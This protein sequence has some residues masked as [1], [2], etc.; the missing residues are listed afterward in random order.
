MSIRYTV[1]GGLT[2]RT[3]LTGLAALGGLSAT[4]PALAAYNS[5][6]GDFR[7]LRLVNSR[8]GERVSTVYWV[9]GQY[10]PEALDA[11][12][13]ILRDWRAER[14]TSMDPRIID[15]LAATHNLLDCGEPF[16]IVSGFRTQGTNAMLRRRSRGVAKKSYHTRGMAVDIALKSRSVEQISGAGKAL[17][18]GG[19]GRYTRSKF[20]H[21]DSGP[22]RDWGR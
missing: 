11:F 18:A 19:V 6:K 12:N 1:S 21:L 22:V 2:R 4:P 9:D 14:A 5:G 8:T 17:S 16:D 20:V 15:I 3:V 7:S 10:I 13:Y